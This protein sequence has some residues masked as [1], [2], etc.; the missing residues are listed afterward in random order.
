MIIEKLPIGTIIIY[1]EKKYII[2]NRDQQFTY[3]FSIPNDGYN[4]YL[5]NY[6]TVDSVVEDETFDKNPDHKRNMYP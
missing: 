4:H 3:C 6:I 1:N 5:Y 2:K